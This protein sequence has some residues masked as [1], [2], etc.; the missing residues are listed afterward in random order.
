MPTSKIEIDTAP[1][2]LYIPKRYYIIYDGLE[3]LGLNFINKNIFENNLI[4]SDYFKNR[5]YII[6][7]D[8]INQIIDIDSINNLNELEIVA[9]NSKIIELEIA[10]SPKNNYCYTIINIRYYFNKDNDLDYINI[11][12]DDYINLINNSRNNNEN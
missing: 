7:L 5:I 2:I 3:L 9:L 4:H 10:K 8:N 6:N 11:F 12:I 1:Y